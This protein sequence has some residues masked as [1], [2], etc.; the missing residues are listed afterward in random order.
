MNP[1][2]MFQI[3]IFVINWGPIAPSGIVIDLVQE[4][5]L[6]GEGDD[7][8]GAEGAEQPAIHQETRSSNIKQKIEN[9]KSS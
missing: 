3:E 9:S 7:G 1:L 6:G 5:P 2:Y 8:G 4:D